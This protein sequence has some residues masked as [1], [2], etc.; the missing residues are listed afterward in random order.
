MG[1]DQDRVRFI[2]VKYAANR[3]EADQIIEQL[4]KNGIVAI[5]RGGIKDIY[6]GGSVMGEE[7]AVSEGDVQK[8]Q[9]ILEIF[10]PIQ[11]TSPE[12]RKEE[13]S[14]AKN[15]ISWLVVAAVVVMILVSLVSSIR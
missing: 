14:R 4:E 5:R 9:E 2:T 15:I 1:K 11:T 8:A 12:N 10:E 6:M 7:I 3:I 13:S